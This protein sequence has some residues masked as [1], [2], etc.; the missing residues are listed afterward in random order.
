M[1]ILIILFVF[2]QSFC[3]ASA[4]ENLENISEQQCELVFKHHLQHLKNLE[5]DRKPGV[6]LFS[7]TQAMGKTFLARKIEDEL[8]G[9]RVSTNVIRSYMDENNITVNRD[10][11]GIYTKYFFT[12]IS[13][14]T[15]NRFFILDSSVCRKYEEI[16][17]FMQAKGID[18]SFLIRI[19]IP[20]EEAKLRLHERNDAGLVLP[21]FEK[22]LTQHKEFGEKFADQFDIVLTETVKLSENQLALLY[23]DIRRKI[24]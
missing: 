20:Y 7:G 8:G 3:S 15:K 21:H 18:K 10:N 24:L 12:K 14:H 1:R 9:I 2:F 4:A 22:Y 6:V 11:V 23:Q 19:E 17:G 16:K 13:E 5:I